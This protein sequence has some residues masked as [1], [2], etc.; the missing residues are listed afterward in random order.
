M[1]FFKA[2]IQLGEVLVQ[3][4]AFVIVFLTLRAMAWK[5]ILKSLENRR[6]KIR[7]EFEHLEKSKKDLEALK[8]QYTALLQKIDEDARA[9]IQQAVDEGR[10]IAKEVQDKA[11]TESQATFEKAK[12]N[13][14]LEVSKA[15]IELRREIADLALAA[16]E[17]VLNQKMSGDSAQQAKILEII[18]ELEKTL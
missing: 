15:R 18:D 11:R 3:L 4:V 1:E 2:N 17:R 6:T 14:N 12:E 9:K 10:R 7:E 13:L 8:S 5:P 16:S